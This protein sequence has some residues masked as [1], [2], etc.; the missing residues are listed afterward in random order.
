MRGQYAVSYIYN[1]GCMS[2]CCRLLFPFISVL[3]FF[4]I[5]C[6][7]SDSQAHQPVSPGIAT[8]EF[9]KE[10]LDTIYKPVLDSIPSTISMTAQQFSCL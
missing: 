2:S 9:Q 7:R 4:I 8:V 3:L 1:P 5:S 10:R 6:R